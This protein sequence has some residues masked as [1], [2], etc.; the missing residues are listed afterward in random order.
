MKRKREAAAVVL[1]AA[2]LLTALSAAGWALTPK[3]YQSGTV[4][5]RYAKEP[6]NSIEVLFLGSSI[7]YCDVAPAEIYRHGGP[8]SY[9]IC[10]PE[11]TLP[12]AYYA[13]RLACRSQSPRAVFLELNGLYFTPAEEHAVENVAFMPWGRERLAASFNTVS[14]RDLPGLLLPVLA[15]HDRWY[16][17]TLQELRDKLRYEPDLFAGNVPTRTVRPQETL[18]ERDLYSDYYAVALDYLKKTAAFCRERD[19]ELYLYL[20]PGYTRLS[21]ERQ[22][23][24]ERDLAGLDHAA[25]LD[26]N[27]PALWA[28]LGLDA[29]TDWR[30]TLHLNMSG[31]EKFSRWLADYLRGRGLAGEPELDEALWQ[32]RVRAWAE[33]RTA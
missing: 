8:S 6:D 21:R 16:S 11:Q 32:S 18:R 7:V 19:M 25:F 20:A 23:A 13:L 29:Q 12:Q 30:D 27:S 9:L 10:G 31:A 15:Y 26:F 33:R 3:L 4:W 24:L 22:A 14:R 17:V 2:L 28:E 1:A 5:E